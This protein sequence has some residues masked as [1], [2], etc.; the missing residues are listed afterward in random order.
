[1]N[2][3][4]YR[5]RFPKMAHFARGNPPGSCTQLNYRHANFST[6]E[7]LLII[8][9][10]LM[11]QVAY[12]CVVSIV[13]A[14]NRLCMHR[15]SFGQFTGSRKV[16][17]SSS[18]G[19]SLASSVLRQSAVTRKTCS[20]KRGE[21]FYPEELPSLYCTVLYRWK[22]ELFDDVSR[23]LNFYPLGALRGQEIPGKP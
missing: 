19:Q 9:V 6:L 7:Y 3:G 11:L 2:T 16:I 14:S 15:T 1:M 23:L 20:K 13:R 5:Q 22:L 21:T 18:E 10:W 8:L 17:Q 4:I 12:N